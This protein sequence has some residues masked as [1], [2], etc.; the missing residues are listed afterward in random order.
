MPGVKRN[1]N[2]TGSVRPWANSCNRVMSCQ[3]STTTVT[4]FCTARA[5]SSLD[6]LLPCST[7]RSG[8]MPPSSAVN[9]SPADTASSPN[10]SE[11]TTAVMA[12]LLL[13]LEA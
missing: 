6:L 10:P 4:P 2:A 12:K 7:I 13:A 5:N 8:G 9:N 11:A 3:L 1:I